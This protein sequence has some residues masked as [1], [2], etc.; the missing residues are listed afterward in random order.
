[1]KTSAK[2]IKGLLES[3]DEWF[4]TKKQFNEFCRALAA[5]KNASNDV[6]GEY[7]LVVARGENIAEKASLDL[8]R[9]L[10]DAEHTLGLEFVG[11]DLADWASHAETKLYIDANGNSWEF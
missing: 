11:R 10:V 6:D 5:L 2:E 3:V 4:A 9:R 7:D 8:W 1:M